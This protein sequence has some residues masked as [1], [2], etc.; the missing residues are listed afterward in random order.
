M[1]E[2]IKAVSILAGGVGIFLIGMA[3]MTDGLKLAAGPALARILSGATRT[4]WQAFASGVLVTAITQSSSVVTIATIG[5]VNAGLLKLGGAL[6]LMFGSNLGSTMMGWIVAVIGLK[7]NIDA[8][9]LPMI[10]IGVA[11]RLSGAASRRGAIG[12]A[13]AG[14]G[15][16]FFG[17]SLL[18]SA[19][20]D[21]AGM[22]RLPD[23]DGPLDVLLQVIVGFVLTCIVQSSAAA[24]AITLTAAQNGLLSA[25]GAAAV[26]IGANVGTTVTAVIAAVGAT[27]NARRA[28]MAH[29]AFNVVAAVL[30]LLLLPWMIRAIAI[31]LSWAGYAV[32]PA[33]QLA[34]FHTTFNVLGVLLMIPLAT[35]LLHWLQRRFRTREEDE[36]APQ[37]LD[38]NVLQVPQLAVDALRREVE[39]LGAM[40]RHM[41]RGA[42]AAASPGVLGQEHASVTRLASVCQSFA[43]RMSRVAMEA[44]AAEQLAD[45]LRTL[46][47]YE[48]AAEQAV[49]AAALHDRTTTATGQADVY[50][51]FLREST[52]LLDH[53]ES[54]TLPADGGESL[55]THAA[56][57][58]AAYGGL[59]A[60]LLA[61]GAAGSVRISVMEEALRR[62]SALQQT[63]KAST[64][65]ARGTDPID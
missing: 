22:I 23:G 7:L 25:Q 9:A 65:R 62:Y 27:P 61:D 54:D 55:G 11:M 18:Q 40:T 20:V 15:L 48:S 63:V 43:E 36:G 47:Y 46:R 64:H 2:I 41:V 6:W 1:A 14:F 44:V 31:G 57:M 26:V 58:E 3:M 50:T 34:I 59:K 42:L 51:A 52:A 24:M 60:K 19:F 37:F 21:M 10:A 56:S 29:V 28:S 17:I 38:D 8:F 16:L 13:L 53:V 33:I 12:N 32:D 30:A 5:F 49:A 35:P 45:T 4:R 39:R